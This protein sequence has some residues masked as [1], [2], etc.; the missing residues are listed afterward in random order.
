MA[1]YKYMNSVI[2]QRVPEIQ[3]FFEDVSCPFLSV[4]NIDNGVELVVDDSTNLKIT[5]EDRG[6]TY[7]T[8]DGTTKEDSLVNWGNPMVW[9]LVYSDTLLFF[10]DYSAQWFGG[11]AKFSYLYEKLDTGDYEGWLSRSG[12]SGSDIHIY[13]Y[14][15]RNKETG[16]AYKHG[17]ML[18]YVAPQNEFG[19]DTL[20]YCTDVLFDP[21]G[22]V[23]TRIEDKNFF[24]SSTVSQTHQI[25]SGSTSGISP[26]ITDKFNIITYN[27]QEY[28]SLE[29]NLLV[30]LFDPEPEP[31]PE[32]N[33]D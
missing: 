28:L 5:V 30:P 2:E 8:I 1:T 3:E 27:G 20:E 4:T 23:I 6:F 12:G 15:L 22:K 24:N 21:S 26:L 29:T 25:P 9:V 19:E 13:E 33:S 17:K 31:N 14:L 11:G 16:A 10:Y 18:N 7:I 32:E